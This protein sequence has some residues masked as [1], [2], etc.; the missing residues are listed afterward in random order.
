MNLAGLNKVIPE[1]KNLYI[2][3]FSSLSRSFYAN[4]ANKLIEQA[5]SV[6]KKS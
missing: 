6:A 2:P 5:N 1:K 4:N 3:Q